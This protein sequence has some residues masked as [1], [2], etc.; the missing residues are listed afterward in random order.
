MKKRWLFVAIPF[1][2]VVLLGSC[3]LFGKPDYVG[4]WTATIGTAPAQSTVTMEFD[5]TTFSVTVDTPIDDY[6]ITGDL[7][8]AE[9]ADTLDATIVAISKNGTALTAAEITGFLALNTLTAAQT[10]TY[11]VTGESITVSGALLLVL[12]G[13]TSITATLVP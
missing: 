3:S 13:A 4:T 10:L 5:K 6:V 2:L 11:V 12:T 1:V 8:E 7:A 9:T